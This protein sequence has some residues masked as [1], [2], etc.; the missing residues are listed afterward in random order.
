[1]VLSCS[2][3][4]Y[5]LGEIFNGLSADGK[6]F[7]FPSDYNQQSDWSWRFDPS[8]AG[9]IRKLLQYFDFEVS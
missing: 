9:A 6:C 5:R 1:M 3:Y 7:E 8:F 2:D 4:P